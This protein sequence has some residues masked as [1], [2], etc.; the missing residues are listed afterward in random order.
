MPAAL[1]T[2]DDY[3]KHDTGPNHP[4]RPERIRAI[5]E[6]IAASGLADALVWITPEPIDRTLLA[7]VHSAT[8]LDQVHALAQHG[9]GLL[10]PDTVVSPASYDV[11]CLAAGGAAAAVSAVLAGSTTSAFA[12]VRPPGHHALPGRGMGFCLFNN[13]AVAAVAAREQHGI[14]HIF[15]IDWD[16]HHGNGTQAIFYRDRTVLYLSLHQEH[17]YPGTGFWEETGAGEGEGFTINIPL[18]AGTGDEGYKLL[19]EEVVVP[20]GQVYAP[21]LIILSA[22]Y[23]AHFADPLGGMLLTTSGFRA[24]TN[25]VMVASQSGQGRVAAILEGGYDLNHLPDA[26]L[27]TLEVFTGRFAKTAEREERF[28]EAPYHEVRARARRARSIVRTYWNI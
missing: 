1:I 20:L 2:H 4:E 27:A 12:L 5:R 16:V 26:V 21:E 25:L 22:G 23:D 7:S 8:Y 13:A 24:L 9:G 10:D 3:L 6:G 17:W 28:S 11:A 18:P 15:L 19:F 14:S